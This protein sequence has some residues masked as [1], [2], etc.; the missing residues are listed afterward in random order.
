MRASTIL[1]VCAL[2]AA[3]AASGGAARATERLAEQ[4]RVECTVCHIKESGKKLTDKGKYYE[5]LRTFNGYDKL[6]ETFG[7]C[8]YC[9]KHKAGSKKLTKQGKRVREVVR[10]M[11]G[12]FEW[13]QEGH[14]GPLE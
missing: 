11:E 2:V 14:T 9:H 7:N 6:T 5:T 12:L 8:L 13:L 10:N 3:V 4:E 1:G